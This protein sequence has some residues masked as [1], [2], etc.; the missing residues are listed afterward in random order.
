MPSLQQWNPQPNIVESRVAKLKKKNKMLLSEMD[1]L[2]NVQ[3]QKTALS[4][5]GTPKR[6][7]S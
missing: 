4:E 7:L 2:R 5:T 1:T 6:K 3:S